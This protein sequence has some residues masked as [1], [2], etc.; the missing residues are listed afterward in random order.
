MSLNIC[1]ILDVLVGNKDKPV[2]FSLLNVL[3]LNNFWR[4]LSYNPSI[5]LFKYWWQHNYI[6]VH[7]LKY[8]LEK[9]VHLS[10]LFSY[11]IS[12]TSLVK[13]LTLWIL[14]DICP[15]DVFRN[16]ACSQYLCL[17]SFYERSFLTINCLFL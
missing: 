13:A 14:L 16:L 8:S 1:K 9:C 3:F 15:L 10:R 17:N 7:Y 4:R 6:N 5:L 11:S 12:S 2:F